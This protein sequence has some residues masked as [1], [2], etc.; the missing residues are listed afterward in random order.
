[1]AVPL[2]ES[3]ARAPQAP[4]FGLG[5]TPQ[6]VTSDGSAVGGALAK[7]GEALTGFAV[8]LQEA[9]D[10]TEVATATTDYLVGLHEAE[11]SGV[12][13]EKYKDAPGE[14]RARADALLAEAT[15]RISNPVRRA[16]LAARLTSHGLTALGRVEKAALARETDANV[17]ALDQ[18]ELTAWREATSAA[19]DT[20]REAAGARYRSAVAAAAA[21]GWISQQAAVARTLRLETNLQRADL[22][23]RMREDPEAARALLDDPA[24]FPALDPVTRESFRNHAANASDQVKIDRIASIAAEDPDTATALIE[25]IAQPHNRYRAQAAIEQVRRRQEAE[26]D[27]AV[28]QAAAASR[29]GDDVLDVIKQ[30]YDA[31]P[32]RVEA[33][34]TANLAAAARGDAAAAKYVRDL[35]TQIALAPHVRRAW[36]TP[37]I[38]LDGEIG[39]ME[40]ELGKAGANVK[41]EQ[42]IAL[43][44]F[45]AVR[46][47]IRK[48]RGSEPIVLGGEYGARFYTLGP[49][50]PRAAPDDPAFAGELARR[51]PHGIAV[52]TMFGGSASVLRAEEATALKDRWSQAAPDERFRLLKTFADNLSGRAYEDTVKAVAGDDAALRYVGRLAQTRPELAR[53]V[54]QGQALIGAAG[55]TD[56]K[57]TVREALR[58]K[59]GGQLYP[60]VGEQNTAIE[61]ARALYVARRGRAGA[62]YEDPDPSALEKAIEEVTGAIVRRNGARVPAP[63]GM[64]PATFDALL[65]N[66]D[67]EGLGAMGG[68]RDGRGVPVT[69]ATIRSYAILKPFDVGGSRYAV[70]LPDPRAHDGFAPLFTHD[71]E[72]L[73]FDARAMAARKPPAKAGP[74]GSARQ[75]TVQEI[76]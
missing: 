50:D 24:N 15:G 46:D 67:A 35:D 69:P 68:A 17:A 3:E 37:L 53:E 9:R 73:V 56:K 5:T 58:S 36:A 59:L 42:V 25:G 2:Y 21:H 4:A 41:P 18:Q 33:V 1:M 13:S 52:Q 71:F 22:M 74:R 20:E 49:L 57:D 39:R 72:P 51:S 29:S 43:K 64:L 62:L 19:S 16:Q 10:Q 6:V 60:D 40:A 8:K 65:D 47:E 32:L 66:L 38:E 55:V 48:R 27:R 30:G 54:M 70:G 61:A 44:A 12:T 7:V 14:F 63:P 11:R 26:L 45:Q 34:R 28:K 76:D 31:D 23:R 75:R